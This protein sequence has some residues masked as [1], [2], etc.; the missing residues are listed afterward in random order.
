MLSKL[1]LKS[2]G[3]GHSKNQK[4]MP[5]GAIIMP[6]NNKMIRDLPNYWCPTDLSNML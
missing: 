4:R 5:K 6:Y 1:D 2:K 3:Q